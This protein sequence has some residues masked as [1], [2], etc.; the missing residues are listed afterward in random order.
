[1]GEPAPEIYSE[2]YYQRIYELEDRHWWYAGM[3][4]I[5]WSLLRPH[6]PRSRGLHVLDAGCGTGSHLGWAK[7]RLRATRVVG[8]DVSRHALRFCRK[9][10]ECPIMQASVSALPFQ[11]DA[12]D[13]VICSDVLQHLPTDGSDGVALK[14]MFRVTRPG[15]VLFV[16]S[17]SRLGGGRQG[18]NRE[19]D[20]QRYS[21]AELSQALEST[22]YRVARATYANALPSL[23]GT[24]KAM[25][26]RRRGGRAYTGLQVRS[27]PPWLSWL[28]AVLRFILKM[29]ARYLVKPGRRSVFG[30]TTILVGV[31]PEV[32]SVN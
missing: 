7:Q 32:Q 2:E 6:I 27:L 18:S 10:G 28:N 13:V 16:R 1:M 14:E 30:H 26:R 12:F 5:A 24:L 22:G 31:K 21:L 15:G 20:F 3:R 29:E 8:V 11:A 4:D 25:H 23:Y 17:N 19:A 9:R